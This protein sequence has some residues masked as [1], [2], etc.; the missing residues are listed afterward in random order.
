MSTVTNQ[1]Q[2]AAQQ[3]TEQQIVAEIQKLWPKARKSAKELGEQLARLQET[4]KDNGDRFGTLLKTIGIPR[5]TAY[6]Y[7]G[8]YEDCFIVDFVF[9]ANVVRFA[10]TANI[11]MT[12]LSSRKVLMNAYRE[13]RSLQD[14]T[15]GEAISIVGSA[16]AA[17]AAAA[18][19]ANA[20]PAPA[21]TP[22]QQCL[23]EQD[24]AFKNMYRVQTKG[25]KDGSTQRLAAEG[26]YVKV[27]Q[28]FLHPSITSSPP[29][30]ASYRITEGGYEKIEDTER[31]MAP[32]ETQAHTHYV[33]D[34]LLR[35][36]RAE[37][38]LY[39]EFKLL[40]DQGLWFF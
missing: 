25:T 10:T 5:S 16:A 34:L 22:L 9:P 6:F 2:T 31:P 19:K 32:K 38:T 14:P 28:A 12:D 1:I 20:A 36:G 3:S 13:I 40:V 11:D 7:I 24:V 4:C 15:D 29:T 39:Q 26:Q 37:T 18:A 23:A 27:A 33:R 35:L 30:V 17:I 21:L 8:I